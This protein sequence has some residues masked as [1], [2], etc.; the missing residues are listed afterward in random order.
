MFSFWCIDCVGSLYANRIFIISVLRAASGP[1]VKVAGRKSAL[2]QT[3]PPTTHTHTHTVVYSAD[4]SGAVVPVIVLLFVV[5]WCILRG[6]LFWVL[7]CVILFHYSVLLALR[8]PRLGKREREERERERERERELILVLFVRLFNMLF[9]GFFSVS[10]SSSCL[11]WAAT[12]NCGTPWPFLLYFWM[13]QKQ[14][15]IDKQN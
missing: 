6:D 4:R 13:P 5:L 11:G 3:P 7:P 9:L 12:C 10:S 2:N 1:R 15:S 14:N 8:L